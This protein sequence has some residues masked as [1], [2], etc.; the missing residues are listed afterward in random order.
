VELEQ[1]TLVADYDHRAGGQLLVRSPGALTRVV[2]TLFSVKAGSGSSRIAV[3]RGRVVVSAARG[4]V[5]TLAAG[6]ALTTGAGPPRRWTRE[7]RQPLLEHA[8]PARDVRVAAVREVPSSPVT[9]PDVSPVPVVPSSRPP[10][11]APLVSPQTAPMP[12]P[13]VA[14]L[15][16]AP[17]AVPATLPPP[18]PPPPVAPAPPPSELLYQRAEQSM[19]RRDWATASRQLAE[20]AALGT[21]HPLEDVARYELAQLALRAGDRAQAAAL[22]DELLRGERE[23]ALRQPAWLLRCE[24]HLQAGQR[25]PG[26]RC[27]ERF[28]STYPGSRHDEQARHLLTRCAP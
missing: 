18:A 15:P 23:P 17:V 12:A 16:V 2:G 24:L 22:L 21:G 19:R 6:D 8:R 4:P 7:D 3:A 25:A 28:R 5:H 1:G 26:C 9:A 14:P 10:D 20:V 13:P 11:A 27:L